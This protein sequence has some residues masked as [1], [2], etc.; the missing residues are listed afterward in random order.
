MTPQR[1]CQSGMIMAVAA[2]WTTRAT[3]GIDDAMPHRRRGTFKQVREAVSRRER[4][5]RQP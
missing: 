1:P 4:L 5:R 2:S 3:A